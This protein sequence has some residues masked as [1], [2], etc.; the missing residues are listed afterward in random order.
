MNYT[1]SYMT[2]GQS[3]WIDF[4]EE[5]KS[6]LKELPTETYLKIREEIENNFDIYQM[7]FDN[8]N[9][10]EKIPLDIDFI[11]YNKAIEFPQEVLQLADDV[12]ARIENLVLKY[13]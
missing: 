7:D 13:E 8:L 5:L 9:L 2:E 1:L 4:P 3:Y 12:Y 11:Y 6:K 10:G